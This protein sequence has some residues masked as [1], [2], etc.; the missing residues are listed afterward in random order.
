MGLEEIR[1]EIEKQLTLYMKEKS[2]TKAKFIPG[3]N[4]VQY[5]G[6]VYGGEELNAM[7]GSIL[8]GWFGVGKTACQFE[9]EFASYLGLSDAIVTNSG[10]SANLIA[11]AALKSNQFKE[12]LEDGDEVIVPAL[13]FPTTFNPI[14]QNH[15]KPVLVDVD[16]GT[17]NPKAEYIEEAISEKTRAVMLLHQLGNPNP[18]DQIMK[19]A[20]KHNLFVIED[21]CDALGSK[22]K[23]QMVG[24]FGTMSTYS[25]YVAHH[26]TMGEG[27]ALATNN[28]KLGLI[29]RSLRDWGRACACRICEVVK[30]PNKPCPHKTKGGVLPDGYD[31][32]YVY[33]NIG[34]NLKPMEFQTA[35]GRVQLKKIDGFIQK[36]NE[37]F[38]KLF[39]TFKPYEEF[40][41]LPE[42]L[43]GAEPAWFAF[44]LTLR[45]GAPFRRKDILQYF[46]AS[47]IETRLFFAGNIIRHPAYLGL[48]FRTVSNLENADKVLRDGFFMGIYPGIT[49]EKMN[50]VCEKIHDYLKRW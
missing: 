40:F 35:M 20:D 17:Y 5:S 24:T 25:F 31:I 46:E 27:G 29:G 50:Y 32:R 26:I 48:N 11:V 15:L 9:E 13:T 42:V 21:T 36:R 18:M 38:R 4:K 14:I 10:S 39:D 47:N 6:P 2:K 45:D 8:D 49:E 30:D 22:Y 19:I 41:I 7:V 33:S 34:Y 12:R 23:G 1:S 16:L 3:K 37:N 28:K 44:P 43:K